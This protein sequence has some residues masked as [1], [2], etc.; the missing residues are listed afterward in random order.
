M[1]VPPTISRSPLGRLLGLK[2]PELKGALDEPGPR[3][4]YARVLTVRG[5]ALS[6]D[7]AP[8]EVAVEVDGATVWTASPSAP[9]ADVEPLFPGVASAATCGFAVQLDADALPDVPEAT[10]I[11]RA[12]R[13]GTRESREIGRAVITRH[14]HLDQGF[15]RTSYGQVWDEI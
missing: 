13:P 15:T 7:G 8:I 2:T 11:A 3:Q 1:A 14:A 5:W 6:T 10:L 4:P 12:R 9:R